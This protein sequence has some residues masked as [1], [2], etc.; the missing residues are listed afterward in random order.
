MEGD[1]EGNLIE[2]LA[3]FERRCLAGHL[4]CRIERLCL[5]E[6]RSG[7]R[8]GHPGI[9]ITHPGWFCRAHEQ[10]RIESDAQ[11]TRDGISQGVAI[12]VIQATVFWIVRNGAGR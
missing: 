6:D 4:R 12:Q 11:V 5:V 7:E 9:P 8:A 2:G 3:L 1:I 10:L